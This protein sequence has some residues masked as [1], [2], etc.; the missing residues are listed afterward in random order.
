MRYTLN[1]W[2]CFST[3]LGLHGNLMFFDREL[4]CTN[5]DIFSVDSRNDVMF[6]DTTEKVPFCA[7][8]ISWRGHGTISA[9]S[10]M[11]D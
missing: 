1:G 8:E 3:L 11:G 10:E 6:M 9:I 4:K 7:I 5:G 2:L